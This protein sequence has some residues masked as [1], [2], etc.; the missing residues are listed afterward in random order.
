MIAV[1]RLLLRAPA[2]G[3]WACGQLALTDSLF[4]RIRVALVLAGHANGIRPTLVVAADGDQI[5]VNGRLSL[6]FVANAIHNTKES[7]RC[8]ATILPAFLLIR[9]V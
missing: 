2:A 7:I 3:I 8:A 4:F 1:D 5:H 6:F 9:E